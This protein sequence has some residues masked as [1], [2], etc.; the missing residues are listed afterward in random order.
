MKKSHKNKYSPNLE[1]KKA[2]SNHR[3]ESFKIKESELSPIK[4]AKE[5]DT[6]TENNSIMHL[7]TQSEPVSMTMVHDRTLEMSNSPAN[8]GHADNGGLTEHN[9]T[10]LI[11]PLNSLSIGADSISDDL[12]QENAELKSKLEV[13]QSKF[14]KLLTAYKKAKGKK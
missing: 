2:K 13:L 1:S 3:K 7:E 8:N 10:V 12:V 4:K 5:N 11:E 6:D 9:A 14:D